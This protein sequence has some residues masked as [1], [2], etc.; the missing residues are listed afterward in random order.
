MGGAAIRRLNGQN[1]LDGVDF[2]EPKVRV[3]LPRP[4]REA[5]LTDHKLRK[6]FQTLQ[7][8]KSTVDVKVDGSNRQLLFITKSFYIE[9]CS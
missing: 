7:R 2:V 8:A 4:N 6:A 1:L 9:Q 3:V 5:I